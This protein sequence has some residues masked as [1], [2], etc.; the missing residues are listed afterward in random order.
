MKLNKTFI[1]IILILI[2]SLIILTIPTINY[3]LK[4]ENSQTNKQSTQKE[5]LNPYLNSKSIPQENIETATLAGG[6]FWCIEAS[7]EQINGI[8]SVESGYTGG[9]I[10]NPTY[11]QVSTGQTGHYEAVKVKYDKTI[12]NYKTILEKFFEL[13]DPTDDTG[14]FSDT[15]SQ[16]KSAIFY[17]NENQ[18]QIA[19]QLIQKLNKS[20]LYNKPIVTKL[21]ENQTFYIAE[22]YHQDYYKKSSTR[23]NQYKKYSGR[24]QYFEKIKQK[25][26]EI[27]E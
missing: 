20:K 26:E 17:K 8:I 15:G 5:N 19:E 13:F 24:P 2:I 9:D 6:C 22:D 14:S 3:K 4:M 27:N 7:L 11:E 10:N 12:I 16:Y 1:T 23:Y 18:K 21:I 25:K